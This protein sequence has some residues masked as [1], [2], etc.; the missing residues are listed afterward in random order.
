[1]GYRQPDSAGRGTAGRCILPNQL[2]G[3]TQ[4]ALIQY[5]PGSCV[6]SNCSVITGGS[7]SPLTYEGTTNWH[8]SWARR[9]PSAAQTTRNKAMYN[10]PCLH[11]T[12]CLAGDVP[13]HNPSDAE[14]K[15]PSSQFRKSKLDTAGSCWPAPSENR[16]TN[17]P[18]SFAQ[19]FYQHLFNDTLQNQQQFPHLLGAVTPIITGT[20]APVGK[21]HSLPPAASQPQ[22]W[23]LPEHQLCFSLAGC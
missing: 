8:P 22:E 18:Q 12:L 1:M 2:L 13:A 10:I 5:K 3:C 4:E 15:S 17:G 14:L 20:L 6:L 9:L 21:R 11:H 7:F 19:H 16:G 23:E